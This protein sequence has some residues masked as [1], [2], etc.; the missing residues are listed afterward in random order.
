MIQ[1]V[2]R[3]DLHRNSWSK[4][5]DGLI[6]PVHAWYSL[7]FAHLSSAVHH[8]SSWSILLSIRL[9]CSCYLITFLN[10]IMFWRNL[11]SNRQ[12]DILPNLLLRL[13]RTISCIC[14][15]GSL[16]SL[17]FVHM[18][19]LTATPFVIVGSYSLLYLLALLKNSTGISSILLVLHDLLSAF[20]M[21]IFSNILKKVHEYMYYNDQP[22]SS[23]M[24]NFNNNMIVLS[25]KQW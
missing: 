25:R 8:S 2:L 20:K 10:F 6:L 13:R 19:L 9:I 3:D 22:H 24:F 15:T 21:F 16:G 11:I 18:T 4:K 5:I 12:H 14:S 1:S 17:Q 23:T 7:W